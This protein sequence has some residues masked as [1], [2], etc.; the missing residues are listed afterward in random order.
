[1]KVCFDLLGFIIPIDSLGFDV[2]LPILRFS[3]RRVQIGCT[4][5]SM[6]LKIVHERERRH[7]KILKKTSD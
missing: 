1:M 6:E 2:I 3:F 4:N 5:K 7:Y